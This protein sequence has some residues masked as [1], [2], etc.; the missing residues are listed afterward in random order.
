MEPA[1]NDEVMSSFHSSKGVN[2]W[3]PGE[4]TLLRATALKNGA[5][6]ETLVLGAIDGSTD[7]FLHAEGTTLTRETAAG[8]AAVTWGGSGT[9]TSLAE[10]GESYYAA[11][12][13]GIYKGTLAGGAGTKVWNTGATTVIGWVKQRL[14][15]GIGNKIY[16]LVGGTPPTLPTEL[17]EHPSTSWRWTAVAEAPQAIY[18]A[19]YAGA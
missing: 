3:V 11:D 10:D 2:P 1:N 8:S 9:I 16:E 12:S 15:A 14:V 6:V 4:L 7:I 17:Y 18:A 13:T 5:S 19:G